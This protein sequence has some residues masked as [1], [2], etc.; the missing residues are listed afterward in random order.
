VTGSARLLLFAA[1]LASAAWAQEADAR[2]V[3]ELDRPSIHVGESVDY[4]VTLHN[5]ESDAEPDLSGFDAFDV[6]AG[7]SS[8][9]TQFINGRVYRQRVFHY[10]LT[11]KGK[12]ALTVPPATLSVGGK[13]L[14]TEALTLL[15][16]P[17]EE[18]NLVLLDLATEP[19]SVYPLQTFRV[20]LRILVRRLPGQ[21]RD[22]DPVEQI[23]SPALTVPWV[24]PPDG[25]ETGTFH[26]W[27]NPQLARNDRGF[28]INGLKVG[29]QSPFSF[30]DEQRL[31]VFDL[32]GHPAGKGRE[33]YFVY[34]LERAFTPQRAG[35]YDFGSV[36]L[37]GRFGEEGAEGR[38]RGHDIYAVSARLLVT[39]KPVP[40]EGKPPSFTGGIGVFRVAAEIAPKR[41]RVGDPMTLTLTLTGRGNLDDIGPPPLTGFEKDFRVYEPTAA[42]KGGERTFTYALRPAH[43]GITAVPPVAL[44]YF[45]FV[46]ERYETIRTDPLPIEVEEASRLDEGSIEAARAPRAGIESAGGGLFAN[47]TDLAQVRDDSAAPGPYAAYAGGLALLYGAFVL[48][49]GRWRSRR[50]DQRGARR[51]NAAKRAAERL[52]SEGVLQAF[53]GLVADTLGLPEAGL[54]AHEVGKGLRELGVAEET[55]QRIDLLL[56]GSEQQRYGGAGA[57][58]PHDAKGLLDEVLRAL[59]RGGRLK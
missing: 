57:A 42:T 49:L 29:D 31:A 30:F 53:G 19:T 46:N 6:E 43:A 47:V 52:L 17:P 25:L 4:V 50:E 2:L 45:D 13:V 51:R 58:G 22:L 27:L 41:A 35:T 20:R 33:D 34:T 18:Q 37:K 48:G 1:L 16:L 12:G 10:R 24:D 3:G 32:K 14:R 5:V 26:D 11:P 59:R 39:V 44:S 56:Q 36:V 38:V 55:A 7:A 15:V 9:Q 8:S 40:E 54:T 23:Q 28:S 21:Y